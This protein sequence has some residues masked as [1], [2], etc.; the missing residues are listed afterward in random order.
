[1]TILSYIK[2]RLLEKT[3]WAG[4]V[5]AITGASVLAEP[6]NYWAMLAGTI[7]VL[8]PSPGSAE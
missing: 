5:G 1:M 4:I 6:W 3:T 2:A 8:V 7:M